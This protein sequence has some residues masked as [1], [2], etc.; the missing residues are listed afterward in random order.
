MMKYLPVN[1]ELRAGQHIGV[2]VYAW[3]NSAPPSLKSR[4]VRGMKFK[5]PSST[6][7]SSVK[8]KMMFG[9]R[10]LSVDGMNGLRT[11]PPSA[12]VKIPAFPL[13][14]TRPRLRCWCWC[15]WLFDL[16]WLASLALINITKIIH[17]ST[18]ALSVV[19]HNFI[20]IFLWK[21]LPRLL[22]HKAIFTSFINKFWIST[23]F[24]S[25]SIHSLVLIANSS[26][27]FYFFFLW[28]SLS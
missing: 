27:S 4:N 18:D 9:F 8:I 20:C 11:G 13:F 7:W 22:T 5:E 1:R 17:S 25:H 12:C 2:V 14:L 6:S 19:D 28:M 24:I 10:S 3:R 23:F 21:F 15:W 26:P 16:W